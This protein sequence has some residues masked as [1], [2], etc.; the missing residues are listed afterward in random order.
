MT[1]EAKKRYRLVGRA[2]VGG[3]KHVIG[4]LVELTDTESQKPKY[5]NKLKYVEDVKATRKP[6]KKK[7]EPV[8]EDA[9]DLDGE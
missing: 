3:V 8:L 4:A 7:G 6:R 2:E 1:K 5:T 9:E